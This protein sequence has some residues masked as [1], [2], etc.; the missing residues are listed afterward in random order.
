MNEQNNDLDPI[1]FLTV[2]EDTIFIDSQ[3]VLGAREIAILGLKQVIEER[4]EDINIKKNNW[5]LINSN[6]LINL[7]GFSIQLNYE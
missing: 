5:D 2:P 4:S 1:E 6:K 3:D 7:N